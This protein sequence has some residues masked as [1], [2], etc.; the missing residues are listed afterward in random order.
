MDWLNRLDDA[1]SD[2]AET[3]NRIEQKKRQR[4]IFLEHR[5]DDDFTEPGLT[6]TTPT[7]PTT[8][9][10]AERYTSS[11]LLTTTP[12]ENN[13]KRNHGGLDSFTAESANS[14]TMEND[15]P[16]TTSTTA[17]PNEISSKSPWGKV[18][19]AISAPDNDKMIEVS[20]DDEDQD[21]DD[22]MHP[23]TIIFRGDRPER[24]LLHRFD[25]IESDASGR[26]SERIISFPQHVVL[27][28][29]SSWIRDFTVDRISTHWDDDNDGQDADPTVGVKNCY[30]VFHLRIL[31]AQRLT[32]P[33]GSWVH[34]IASLPP[35]KGKVR[36]PKA[37]AFAASDWVRTDWSE[38]EEKSAV[39]MVHAYSSEDSPIPAIH[40]ALVFTVGMLEFEMGHVQI[41][42]HALMKQPLVPKS[43]WFQMIVS[44]QQTR[45]QDQ[46]VI[47]LIQ[48]EAIFEPE[49]TPL[50]D[51][52][53]PSSPEEEDGT[54][55]LLDEF[56]TDMDGPLV[57]M[58]DNTSSF[59]SK[60][61]QPKVHATDE[62]SVSDFSTSL[63]SF[64][65]VD[66]VI[67]SSK[68]HHFRLEAFHV[69]ARC[70]VCS[71][72]ITS[73][74]FAE[75]KAFHCEACGIDCC[76][77]CR[78]Q[79]DFCLPCGSKAATFA[80][81]NSIQSK[82]TVDNVLNIVAPIPDKQ[83]SHPR[84]RPIMEIVPP[85]ER[86]GKP[87]DTGAIGIL[88]M[89]IAKAVVLRTPLSPLSF[90]S[91]AL[92]AQQVTTGDYYVRISGSNG[93]SA[94]T[95]TVQGSGRPKFASK[96]SLPVRHYGVDFSFEL[97]DA[98]TDQV[99]GTSILP[100]K[101]I[102]QEQRDIYSSAT[103]IPFVWI[104][105]GPVTFNQTRHLLLEL[106]KTK[107]NQAVNFFSS[108]T[109][110]DVVALLDLE[111]I[112]E[113][114]A[115]AL[116]AK[117]P[118]KCPPKPPDQ[119]DL[120]TFQSHIARLSNLIRDVKDLVDLYQ[121]L[122]SWDNPTV[123]TICALVYF[124]LCISFNLEYLGA[125]PVFLLLVLMILLGFD[126]AQGR[127]QRRFIRRELVK[128]RESD[129]LGVGV[130]RPVGMVT[131]RI[132][133][134]CNLRSPE[135]GLPGSAGCRVFLD[136][137]R[138]LNLEGKKKAE[139]ADKA[140][141]ARH[142]L[143]ATETIYSSDPVW[144]H[145]I[146]SVEAKRLRRLVPVDGN[147]FQNDTQGEGYTLDFPLLQP[148]EVD[149][150]N[151]TLMPWSSSSAALVFE[152]RFSDVV[153]IVPGTEYGLGEVVVPISSLVAMKE[154]R[155]WFKLSEL[156][157]ISQG[158]T[159]FHDEKTNDGS[160]QVLIHLTWIS[161]E[162]L[163]H[164]EPEASTVIQEEMVRAA[165][166]NQEQT[167]F[168]TS[169]GAFN[170]VRGL[171]S[172][173]ASVQNVLGTILDSVEAVLSLFN[174]SDPYK[175]TI[176]FVLLLLLFAALSTVPS[177]WLVVVAGIVQ[178]GAK[179]PS[180][181]GRKFS[182]TPPSKPM[183]EKPVSGE[184]PVLTWISNAFFGLPT[185][186]DLRRTYYWDTRRVV[187]RET[188]SRSTEKRNARL[189]TLWKAKW[190]GDIDMLIRTAGRLERQPAFGVVQGH[191]FL[192]W[193]SVDDFDA[194]AMALGQLVLSGHAGVA[195][196]SPLEMKDLA[197]EDKSR[198]VSIFGR[199]KMFQQ[200]LTF[201]CR[202]PAEKESFEEAV[203][204]A[205]DDK[206]E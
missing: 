5:N 117:N 104:F 20:L 106:R 76:G 85:T 139:S 150:H 36:T 111:M 174:F 110:G 138:F 41:P 1:L 65:N 171:S 25:T 105:G 204:S 88:K 114:D 79:V 178:F 190:Y 123:T 193:K 163:P 161:P 57:P 132:L 2:A 135:L 33:V 107:K 183:D 199:G 124:Y 28:T 23:Q 177:R 16:N 129:T 43:G 27:Q 89:T 118:Y 184:S 170:T 61:A 175:S 49:E 72:S 116:Y 191:R 102:L 146:E 86:T 74:W 143:G 81:K 97:I 78:L 145:V 68:I 134:G 87:T 159:K 7:T 125:L 137:C 11:S 10:K 62:P 55:E 127:F 186:E 26:H 169:I 54:E 60:M 3:S 198:M 32:C 94:R 164:Q 154:I 38:L 165:V 197:E 115:E 151:T 179:L 203:L 18:L 158:G 70:A 48:M 15:E 185:D 196:P 141:K 96:L 140:A 92:T 13:L 162:E 167:L 40:V 37:R 152:I 4:R 93:D 84:D 59:K 136:L 34:A 205:M 80:A 90:P 131:V 9:N 202:G 126:R 142:E 83:I 73:L 195:T 189:R 149:G 160:P 113:E 200:R 182:S 44:F 35:W 99:V 63:S 69:L 172:S 121:Y 77:D 148:C 147:F 12:R 24:N 188:H 19:H 168:G 130:Y 39:S 103:I 173:F 180:K 75:K 30:G 109:N 122:V 6:T 52:A 194:S 46:K 201:L 166:A 21:N 45:K 17:N 58:D 206:I 22:P 64:R 14:F 50:R 66:T 128:L 156:G 120:A 112:L 98:S 8:T 119:L 42:C 133:E 29:S 91:D 47:P 192:F 144:N 157:T 101:A 67:S 95:R 82:L 31:R 51:S 153:S 100:A 56:V 71:T 187:A 181:F 53:V 155:G 176:V 108:E